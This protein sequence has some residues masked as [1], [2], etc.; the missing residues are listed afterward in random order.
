M[1]EIACKYITNRTRFWADPHPLL[2]CRGPRIFFYWQLGYIQSTSL[3]VLSKCVASGGVARETLHQRFALWNIVSVL[4]EGCMSGSTKSSSYRST[5][6]VCSK[7]GRGLAR[8]SSVTPHG[9][10]FQCCTRSA[11][12]VRRSLLSV[13]PLLYKFSI[14]SLAWLCVLSLYLVATRWI[15]FVILGMWRSLWS[16][17]LLAYQGAFTIVLRNFDWNRW[18]SF[19]LVGLAHPHNWTPYDQMGLRTTVYRKYMLFRDN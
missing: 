19:N 3:R 4:H 8:E 18:V 16:S 14:R 13:C 11:G 7:W 17:R 12:Q 1:F 2:V 6:W 15:S 9:T 5:E 10:S